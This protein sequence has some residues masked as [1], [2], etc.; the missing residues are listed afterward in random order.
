MQSLHVLHCHVLDLPK[1]PCVQD[2]HAHLL[3]FG[4][5]VQYR[6]GDHEGD[7]S[8]F[9][10]PAMAYAVPTS[11]LGFH[12]ECGLFRNLFPQGVRASCLWHRMRGSSD[13][14]SCPTMF[15]RIGRGSVRR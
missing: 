10:V 14:P 3:D 11:S 8:D 15:S 6:E 9:T 7:P 2:R 13:L 5:V 4:A 12:L 1:R